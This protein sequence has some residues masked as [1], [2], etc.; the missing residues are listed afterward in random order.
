MA[1]II[2][3]HGF[4]IPDVRYL[5]FDLY[6]AYPAA[7]PEMVWLENVAEAELPVSLFG[8]GKTGSLQLAANAGVLPDGF[9]A[10]QWRV[11]P[12]YIGN[13]LC[14]IYAIDSN[15]DEH[16]IFAAIAE[17]PIASDI[18]SEIWSVK[19]VDLIRLNMERPLPVNAADD[20]QAEPTM[21]PFGNN[22]RVYG[23]PYATQQ[24]DHSYLKYWQDALSDKVGGDFGFG[25]DLNFIAGW[26]EDFPNNR[27]V[28]YDYDHQALSVR[29]TEPSPTPYI[30]GIVRYCDDERH[31][32]PPFFDQSS[33]VQPWTLEKV[34]YINGY[35][36]SQLQRST[37]SLSGTTGGTT[38]IT[39]LQGSGYTIYGTAP[40]KSGWDLINI[41]M[42]ISWSTTNIN[43]CAIDL[44]RDSTG[45]QR[46]D[47]DFTRSGTLRMDV[48]SPSSTVDMHIGLQGLNS[49][50]TGNLTVN[51]QSGTAYYQRLFN[52]TNWNIPYR[53]QRLLNRQPNT[54]HGWEFTLDGAHGGIW[55]RGFPDSTP[56]QPCSA[57]IQYKGS[58]NRSSPS[59]QTQ[60]RA[61]PL[62]SKDYL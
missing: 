38:S 26:P 57:V 40:I 12:N 51:Y 11:Y 3:K 30:T 33:N 15:N 14:L 7:Q 34:E 31:L 39:G 28:Y 32:Q 42:A 45:A 16:R 25:P 61:G 52:Y 56:E 2:P 23:N 21:S 49:S 10:D 6:S 19:L 24:E 17:P 59:C 36:T 44:E 58:Y 29:K 9:A 46:Y 50:S 43:Q 55:A 37:E 13:R 22:P 8:T 4:S 20:D 47:A 54:K 53:I 27:K 62:P 1:I 48:S 60:L 18:S 5:R 35:V 41:K